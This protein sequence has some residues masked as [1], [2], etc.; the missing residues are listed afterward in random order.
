MFACNVGHAYLSL[1]NQHFYYSV[2]R[3]YQ[4]YPHLH[5]Q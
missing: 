3:Q 2:I 4:R 5:H 1:S